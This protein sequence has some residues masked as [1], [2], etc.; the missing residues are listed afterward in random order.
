MNKILLALLFVCVCVSTLL[1]G[2]GITQS[3]QSLYARDITFEKPGT[4]SVLLAVGTS[5]KTGLQTVTIPDGTG[6]IVTSYNNYNAIL[7]AL[8]A[9]DAGKGNHS[10]INWTSLGV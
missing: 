5:L 2:N 3:F 10:G 1:V 7:V 6:T 4:G 9:L 8:K